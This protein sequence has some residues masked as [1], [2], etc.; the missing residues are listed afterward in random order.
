MPI[1]IRPLHQVFAGEVSGIDCRKP[2]SARVIDAVEAG[3][4][5]K[6]VV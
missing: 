3:I 2:L 5:R 1:T 6:S 4:D